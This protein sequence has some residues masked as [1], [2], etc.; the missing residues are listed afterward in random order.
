MAG[1]ETH[2]V[3]FGQL[4]CAELQP[5]GQTP[6]A[7]QLN[8]WCCSKLLCEDL[9]LTEATEH[10]SRNLVLQTYMG[11]GGDSHMSIQLH[12]VWVQ[13]C[14]VSCCACTAPMCAFPECQ[15]HRGASQL[16]CM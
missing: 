15:Q 16:G 13:R 4:Q 9:V 7:A 6:E 5:E 2:M 1:A 3:S 8:S 11:C 12:P 14:S 10:E